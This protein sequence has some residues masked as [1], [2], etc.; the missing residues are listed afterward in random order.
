MI[1]DDMTD[2]F[3]RARQ[4]AVGDRVDGGVYVD[5]GGHPLWHFE[6]G[7]PSGPPTVL[8]HGAFAS[9][10]TWG[11]QIAGFTTAGLHVFVPERTGHGHTPDL[12][13]AWSLDALADQM[14]DYLDTIVGSPA[15]LVGWSDGGVISLLVARRRPDLVSRLVT[16]C[17]YV[18]LAGSDAAGFFDLVRRR[19]EAMLGFL[20]SNYVGASP[21]G[22]DHFERAYDKT[23]HTLL[24]EPDL[25]VTDF[26]DV[27][28]PT[29]V[30]TADK[31]VVRIEHSLELART[32]P[33]GRLA[34][35]PGTHLVPLEAPELV[36]PLV[37]SFLAADPPSRWLP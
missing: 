18:N 13:N 11:T 3:T 1:G 27:T 17:T 23:L 32:L 4:V 2:T 20:R 28:T 34:V 22:A 7:D 16:L 9:A 35:L 19:D 14:I 12:D 25:P 33:H 30:A 26:A 15:H 36:N 37:M 24:T 5:V 29:L 31:G 21:D 8:V 6:G 10:A